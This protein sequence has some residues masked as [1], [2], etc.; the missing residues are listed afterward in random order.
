MSFLDLGG[1][2]LRSM[3]YCAGRYVLIAGAPG[4]GGGASRLYEW[5]GKGCAQGDPRRHAERLES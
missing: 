4:E 3:E 1:F 5:D 2:G